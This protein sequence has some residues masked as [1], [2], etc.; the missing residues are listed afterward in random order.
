MYSTSKNFKRYVCVLQKKNQLK[1]HLYKI[2]N[3]EPRFYNFLVFFVHF[4]VFKKKKFCAFIFS[5]FHSSQCGL[6]F[7]N[8]NFVFYL[9]FITED[10]KEF[11][12]FS[13]FL[14]VVLVFIINENCCFFQNE[15]AERTFRSDQKEPSVNLN[16]I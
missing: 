10:E 11:L 2:L 16:L 14:Y 12:E 15:C 1:F 9:E 5:P 7:P 4:V 13:R 8:K 3:P 6:S